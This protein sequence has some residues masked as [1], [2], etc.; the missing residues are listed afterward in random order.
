MYYNNYNTVNNPQHPHHP[1][2]A[3]KVS[4]H[5][6]TSLNCILTDW[7]N[8]FAVSNAISDHV[9]NTVQCVSKAVISS[10]YGFAIR[11]FD[12]PGDVL[13][14][15]LWTNPSAPFFSHFLTPTLQWTLKVSSWIWT[16]SPTLAVCALLPWYGGTRLRQWNISFSIGSGSDLTLLTGP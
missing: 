2:G 13:Y 10:G 5:T 16:T 8:R 1:P 12:I 11:R 15:M 7:S 3:C 9:I 6:L 4:V 14:C